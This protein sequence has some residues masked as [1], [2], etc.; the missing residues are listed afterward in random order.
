M[1]AFLKALM[2]AWL[3]FTSIHATTAPMQHLS[4]AGATGSLGYLIHAVKDFEHQYPDCTVSVSGGGS[5]A[6]LVEVS[7]GRIDV[8]VS[9]LAPRPQWTGGQP[10]SS[11]ALGQTPLLVIAHVGTG[12]NQVS[13]TSLIGLMTGRIASWAAVGGRRLP[14][15]VMTRPLSSGAR[16][17]LQEKIL[18]QAP[19]APQAVVMLSNGAML[20]AVQETPGALGYLESK[21][22]PPGVQVLAVGP[23]RFSEDHPQ[24]WPWSVTPMLYWRPT[25]SPLVK[26]LAQFLATRPYRQDYGLYPLR[27]RAS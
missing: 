21:G 8:G 27:R 2:M 13:P 6:G 5:I 17:T 3:G 14:V 12:V 4:I 26:T 20:A 25:A 23:V 15:V 11:R 9:D 16:L 18:H 10:L 1:M 22:V 19:M 24:Q 7:R